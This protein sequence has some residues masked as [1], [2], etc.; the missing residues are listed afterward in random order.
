MPGS[1]A[2]LVSLVE[3]LGIPS[4]LGARGRFWSLVDGA[5]DHF[6]LLGIVPCASEMS[7]SPAIPL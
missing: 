1:V 6:E 2:L 3:L 4:A 5:N 7:L